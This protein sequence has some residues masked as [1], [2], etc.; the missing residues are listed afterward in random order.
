MQ[1]YHYTKLPNKFEQ[2]HVLVHD[3]LLLS[4]SDKIRLITTPKYSRKLPQLNEKR[5][6]LAKRMIRSNIPHMSDGQLNSSICILKVYISKSN[7]SVR[8]LQRLE[9]LVAS[10]VYIA[11][12]R[13]GYSVTLLQLSK[14]FSIKNYKSLA[15]QI[16]KVAR[17]VGIRSFPSIP[18]KDTIYQTIQR[19]SKTNISIIE[20]ANC[21]KICPQSNKVDELLYKNMDSFSSSERNIILDQLICSESYMSAGMQLK[22]TKINKDISSVNHNLAYKKSL[23]GISSLGNEIL[24]KKVC[25]TANSLLTLQTRIDSS[26]LEDILNPIWSVHGNCTSPYIG[27]SIFL[28]LRACG[29]YQFSMSNIASII[30]TSRSS[31]YRKKVEMTSNIK[32]LMHKLFPG[33]YKFTNTHEVLSPKV[34][35]RLTELLK[36]SKNDT[37]KIA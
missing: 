18:M 3:D 13:E 29:I 33:L 25:D 1:L 36:A 14:N 4:T 37:Y 8:L 24:Y 32:N 10:C 5:I 27:A 21:Q 26:S 17:K 35:V 23:K 19:I 30:G 11:T 12:R 7:Y 15:C 2:P 34:L 22:K 31:I 28:A 20:G 16:R 6:Q 9:I